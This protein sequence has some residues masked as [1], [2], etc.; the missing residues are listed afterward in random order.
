MLNGSLLPH[1]R[2]KVILMEETTAIIEGEAKEG[3]ENSILEYS[4]DPYWLNTHEISVGLYLQDIGDIPL[5]NPDEERTLTQE[6]AELK[7]TFLSLEKK[8]AKAKNPASR[9]ELNR[10]LEVAKQAYQ[11]LKN[12]IVEANLRLVV[13]IAK[14]YRSTAATAGMNSA[15]LIQEGN[16]GLMKAIDKFEPSKGYKLSTYAFWWIRQSILR[17]IDNQR[18]LVRHPVGFKK[19]R[20]ELM[21]AQIRLR[22]AKKEVTPDNLAEEMGLRPKVVKRIMQGCQTQKLIPL[23]KLLPSDEGQITEQ[24]DFIENR[25]PLPDEEAL[26]NVTRQTLEAAMNRWLRPREKE[27]LALRFGFDNGELRTL[28]QVGQIFGVSRERVRQ[29]QSDALE[30]LKR[31]MDIEDLDFGPF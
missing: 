10:Q 24:G 6:L 31:H 11:A 15:D 25:D 22:R 29:I 14:K 20:Q 18:Y 5:L 23:N 7:K 13:H 28:E 21:S 19:K 2:R 27:V 17:A 26:A 1:I 30:K 9:Q 16:I 12:K 4:N 3:E 8:I